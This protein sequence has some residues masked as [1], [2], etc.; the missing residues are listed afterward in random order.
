M[1]VTPPVI[2]IR[3]IR[4][5]LN[6]WRAK[7]RTGAEAHASSGSSSSAEATS[8]EVKKVDPGKVFQVWASRV[9]TRQVSARLKIMTNDY[10]WGVV[11]VS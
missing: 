1:Q 8:E 4:R 9:K 7:R 3:L 10:R 6:E 11:S 2:V 5:D